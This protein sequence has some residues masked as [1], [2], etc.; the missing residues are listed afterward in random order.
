MASNN[1]LFD[2]DD[3]KVVSGGCLALIIGLALVLLLGLGFF[4]VDS[5]LNQHVVQPVQR[6]N[7][8]HDAD[9]QRAQTMKLN[10]A[11]TGF[12]QAQQQLKS[13][14]LAVTRFE[15]AHGNPKDYDFVTQQQFVQVEQDVTNDQNAELH[16]A[17]V[18]NEIATNPDERPDPFPTGLPDSLSVA[19]P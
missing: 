13:D 5:Q 7:L 6:Q 18:Y 2:M 4:Y 9:W 1:N 8:N 14:E 16:Y 3:A 15:A 19:T 10:N 12:Q 11:Y 17:Q